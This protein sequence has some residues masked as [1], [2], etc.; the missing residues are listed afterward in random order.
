MNHRLEFANRFGKLAGDAGVFAGNSFS[1]QKSAVLLVLLLSL[2]CGGGGEGQMGRSARTIKLA[3][4]AL[5]LGVGESVNYKATAY[6]SDGT[7]SDVTQKVSWSVA[8]TTVVDVRAGGL[9]TGM[10]AGSGTV[11][12]VLQTVTGTTPVTVAV[13]EPPIDGLVSISL[14]PSS[15]YVWPPKGQPIQF[16]ATGSFSDGTTRDITAEVIWLSSNSAAATI[17]E[18]G[19]AVTMT[20]VGLGQTTVITAQSGTVRGTAELLVSNIP[21]P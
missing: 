20:D 14:V 13:L 18:S 12:A 7:S 15:V 4:E 1:V 11:T 17:N 9:V 6:Y 21:P 19:L 5:L 8:P 10:T 2:A 3:P 16:A